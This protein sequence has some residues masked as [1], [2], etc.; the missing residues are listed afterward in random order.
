MTNVSFIMPNKNKQNIE[1]VKV[2]IIK[3][4]RRFRLT[5]IFILFYIHIMYLFK[6]SLY[7]NIAV[8]KKK[9]TA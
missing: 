8:L 3:L 6:R 4:V 9:F 7:M 2:L 5:E 1:L